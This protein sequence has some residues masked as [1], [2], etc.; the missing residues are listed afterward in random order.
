MLNTEDDILVHF[1]M[2]T[3]GQLVLALFSAPQQFLSQALPPLFPGL[4]LTPLL[5]GGNWH[6]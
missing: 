1:L 4:G 5:I 6:G 3:S 2:Q